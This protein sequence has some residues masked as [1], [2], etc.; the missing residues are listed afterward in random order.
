MIIKFGHNIIG[1][2]QPVYVIAEAGVNHNG[3]IK[4]A[5]QLVDVAKQAGADCV[6]FQTFTADEFISDK[7]STYTYTSQ[8]KEVTESQYEMFK[9]LEFSEKDW[10]EIINYCKEK[11]VVFATTAQ[12]PADLDFI[13]KLASLPFIKVGSDDLT[14]LDLI[15]DYAE[16]GIPMVISAGMSDEA[17]ISDAVETIKQAGNEQIIVL[18]CVS[19]YPAKAQEVNLKK[20]P[21]IKN[22]FNVIVGFSDH[23]Q[24][25]AAATGAVYFDSKVIEKHFTLSHDLP[26]PDH[27]FSA[28]PEELKKYIIDIRLAEQMIGSG[29]IVPTANEEEIKK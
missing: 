7:K 22:K 4:L 19:S 29:E 18:H 9:R 15:S 6:K 25:S 24:G 8:G 27:W 14:S 12:S 5:K 3:D 23:T 26:G 2:N 28:D 1:D 16:K 20:I 21:A 10:Q 11:G 17:E 13:L